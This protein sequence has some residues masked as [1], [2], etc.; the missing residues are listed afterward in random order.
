M[1][2]KNYKMVVSVALVTGMLSIGIEAPGASRTSGMGPA[3]CATL[4][5]ATGAVVGGVVGHERGRG[6]EGAAAGC[7]AGTLAGLLAHEIM[8]R[9]IDTRQQVEQ[10]FREKGREIPAEPMVE[11]E[12]L[13][14]SPQSVQPGQAVTV[15]GRYI[16]IGADEPKPQGSF[17]LL[18]DGAQVAAAP[19]EISN[20]GRSEFEKKILVPKDFADGEYEC[21]VLIKHGDSLQAR[22]SPF[23]VVSST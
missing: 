3:G 16:A 20:T 1:C 12:H 13:H 4:G 9:Q 7:A 8:E 5:G 21:E 18:K 15:Q 14:A 2:R 22:R 17:R 10:E 19:L 23:M 11:I 6:W